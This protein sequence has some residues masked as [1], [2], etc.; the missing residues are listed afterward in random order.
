MANPKK[1]KGDNAE[2]EVAKLLQPIVS[3]YYPDYEI[4]RNLEQTRKG[5]CD[6]II[7]CFDV[8]V[9]RQETPSIKAWWRQAVDQ[10]REEQSPMLIYRGSRQPWRALVAMH[11][12]SYKYICSYDIQHAV[13][14]EW[15]GLTDFMDCYY[16]N[17]LK[18]F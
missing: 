12:I 2:R 9:K 5:G 10:C 18:K 13:T 8:E 3:K 15:P 4:E 17:E 7:P 11:T 6:L 14:L 1:R 16:K